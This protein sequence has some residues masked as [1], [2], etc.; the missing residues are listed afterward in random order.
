MQ[1]ESIFAPSNG[2]IGL[3]GNLDEGEPHGLPGAYLHSFHELHPLP[4]VEAGYGYP[5]S[6][7]AVINVTIGKLIR[8]PVDEE[9]FAVANG[10][11]QHHEQD[12]DPPSPRAAHPSYRGLDGRDDDCWSLVGVHI[13]SR[14]AALI[15]RPERRR[16]IS[17]PAHQSSFTHFSF[18]LRYPP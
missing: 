13:V 1:T 9:P 6:G 12:R 17:R 18:P 14:H 11:V 3:R 2:H 10:K 4:Y 7:H 15:A 8:L 5:E 16:G